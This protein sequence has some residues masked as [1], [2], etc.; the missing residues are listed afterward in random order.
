M[1]N[2]LC[3]QTFEDVPNAYIVR[4]FGGSLLSADIRGLS[5]FKGST[6]TRL[7]CLGMRYSPLVGLQQSS[8]KFFAQGLVTSSGS[9]LSL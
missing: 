8:C 5:E 2:I 3:A 9:T 7:F 4:E 6:C 1:L